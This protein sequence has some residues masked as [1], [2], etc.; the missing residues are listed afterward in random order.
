MANNHEFIAYWRIRNDQGRKR[1]EFY[2]GQIEWETVNPDR[3]SYFQNPKIKRLAK[4]IVGIV[5][6]QGRKSFNGDFGTTSDS[7][8]HF[9]EAALSAAS[10]TQEDVQNYLK[11]L[12]P[13]MSDNINY[14][15]KLTVTDLKCLCQGKV[16]IE[17]NNFEFEKKLYHLIS[18]VKEDDLLNRAF[19]LTKEDVFDH[20]LNGFVGYLC[21]NMLEFT[22]SFAD[23]RKIKCSEQRKEIWYDVKPQ[24]IKWDDFI[25]DTIYKHLH[26]DTKIIKLTK[27]DDNELIYDHCP[28]ILANK[29]CKELN[30]Q[31]RKLQH[32]KSFEPRKY[33]P[34][35]GR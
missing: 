1:K 15:E 32:I 20:E 22:Y 18:F 35:R 34:D 21:G 4:S 5:D 28:D 26:L 19:P 12:Y 23:E 6:A 11:Q 8:M 27:T 16:H 33:Y 31:A 29:H 2:P 13:D 30:E 9:K 7:Q 24:S 25:H 17:R 10:V 14:V 3:I